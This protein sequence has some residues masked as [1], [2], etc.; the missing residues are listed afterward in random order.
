MVDEIKIPIENNGL[1][2][3]NIEFMADL[4][5]QGLMLTYLPFAI[6]NSV[7]YVMT[8]VSTVTTCDFQ[9]SMQTKRRTHPKTA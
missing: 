7:V 1:F 9:H 3:K 6:D 8:P 4:D 5:S 2:Q